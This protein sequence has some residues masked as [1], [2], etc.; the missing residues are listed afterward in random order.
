MRWRFTLAAFA[1]LSVSACISTASQRVETTALFT[2]RNVAVR[3]KHYRSVG[4]DCTS[5]GYATV[6]LASAPRGGT[7]G[8]RREGEFPTFAAT[9][10]RFKC[11]SRKVEGVGVYYT[12][13]PGFVGTDSFAVEVIWPE[14]SPSIE[15]FT[16]QV[17]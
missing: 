4:P 2:S 1:A 6:T 3:A 17:R 9:H 15:D 8:F 5:L 14:G 12:P 16:V 13:N 10:P 11:N 7:I